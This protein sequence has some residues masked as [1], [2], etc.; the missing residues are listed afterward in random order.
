MSEAID[1]LKKKRQHIKDVISKSQRGYEWIHEDDALEAVRL[2]RKEERE[3]CEDKCKW[4]KNKLAFGSGKQKYVEEVEARVRKKERER[5]ALICVQ[6][7]E[8][9]KKRT[10]QET[11]KE[12]KEWI[13]KHHK[14]H[15]DGTCSVYACGL[16]NF[17]EKR[18]LFKSKSGSGK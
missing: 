18:F 3:K 16:D 14:E 4:E 17:I 6:E 12:I 8:E 11:A 13:K 10:K 15:K 7:L 9:T 1:Y 2:A 5:M